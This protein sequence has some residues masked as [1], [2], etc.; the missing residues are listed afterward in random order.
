MKPH[1]SA[2]AHV[3]RAR[4]SPPDPRGPRLH[5]AT[6]PGSAPA[7][8]FDPIE[9]AIAEI[10]A[11]RPV[12]VG[13]ESRTGEGNLVFAAELATSETV[14]F[15]VRHTSGFICVAVT[16][17]E[18]DR[19]NLPP[20]V[21]HLNQDTCATAY[22]VTVDAREG[23]ETGIS[24]KDRATT[25]ALLADPAATSADLTRP[26]H[27]VP[28]RATDAGVLHRPEPAEAAVDLA[29]LAGLRPAAALCEI[30]SQIDPRV[31]AEAEELRAFADKHRLA[32][33]SITDLIAYRRRYDKL[34]ERVASARLPSRYG[35][36][37][38]HRYA[39]TVDDAEHVAIVFGDLGNGQDVLVRVHPECQTG[40]LFGSLGCN[41]GA[42]LDG[43]LAAVA[44]EGRGAV[45]YIRGQACHGIGFVRK[46]AVRQLQ[47]ASRDLCEAECESVDSDDRNYGTGAQILA[48]LGI[49]TIRLLTDH[50]AKPA[51]LERY[52]LSVTGTMPLPVKGQ[53][54]EPPVPFQTQPDRTSAGPWRRW[55]SA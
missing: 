47:D 50:P 4:S 44:R 41:C 54:A 51:G 48:D 31:M 8:V 1:M 36:Y 19:L 21:L 33:V 23:I 20:M 52:G 16:E 45:L 9:L 6:S 46:P 2:D 24:A 38:A 34:V 35:D 40:D 10:A 53:P 32:M 3:L 12:V 11:G 37:T 18:A 55:E 39:S 17:A 26:G 43:A 14:A 28:L 25:I 42:A 30:V 29:V 13:D 22:T 15:M 27:V 49:V 5:L 7:V